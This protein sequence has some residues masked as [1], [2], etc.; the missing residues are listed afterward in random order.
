[1]PARALAQ[2]TPAQARAARVETLLGS[3]R[4]FVQQKRL[5]EAEMQ[6]RQAIQLAWGFAEP[7]LRYRDRHRA[8]RRTVG[9]Y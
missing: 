6:L 2:Q 1:M 4:A 5:P 8:I 3:G 7:W 9:K